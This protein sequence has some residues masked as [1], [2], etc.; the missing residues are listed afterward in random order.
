[1]NPVEKFLVCLYSEPNYLAVNILENLLANNCFVNIVTEDV[2]GWIEKTSY[3]AAKNRFSVGNSKSFSEN[4]YYSYILFCSGFLDKKNL[5]QDVNKFLKTVDYQNKKTFFILPGEV[6]GEI[7]IGLQGDTTNAGII[8]LGDV[9]GP[10]IDLQSN[11]KIP[12]YLN[13]I[14]NSRSLTMPV[15]E[16]LY[17]IF[18][19]DAAKQLVKWLFAFGPFGKEI[20]LIGQDTSSSTFWQVNTKLIGEIKLNTVTDSASGKL[21]KGVE[22]FRINKDLTFTLTETYKWISLKPV[23]QTRKPTKKHSFKKAKILILTLLL[24]F[25]LPI[26]TLLINGGLSYFSYRQFLSG[27]SQVSQNLLYVNKFVSNIGYFES[28]VLKHIP[29]IGHFYKESEYMSYVITN[30]SK[31]GIE[32]IPV[33]RTGG[34]LISNILGD[35]SYSFTARYV[36]SKINFETYKELISQT[37]IIVDK[38]PNVLGRED[39]KTYFVLFENNMELRPTGGF[40]GSYGLLTFD[41]GRLSDFAISD[42]YSADGQLNGHV[43]PPL[44][45]KQY[46][47]EANWWLRDS[48]WD[49]DFPTSA[50][51]A[52]WFLDKEMDKQVDGVISVDLTPIKSFLKIS[53]PIFL[54]DYNM[55]INADNL[56]EK[57]QSEVQDDFFAGTHKKASFLTALSRSIL[58][59]TGGLSSTQKTSVLKLVYDNLDQR[60]IQVFLHDSE[61]QNTMEVLGWDGSVFTP[62]CSGNCYSDLVGIVEANVGVNKSNYFVTREANLDIEIDEA[63]ID[64][65]MTLT[66]KNSASANLGLSGRYKSYVRLLIPE[67]SIAIRAESS[68]GQNT[69]V[70]NPEITNSKGR[71]EV[72]TIVEVLAGETKQLVFYWSAELSKQVDQYDVYIRK[73][74]GVDGYPVNVSVTDLTYQ[75]SN[76][77]CDAPLPEGY[78]YWYNTTLVRDLF[79]RFSY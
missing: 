40:I 57:V 32:G 41:K 49:P 14:I 10:R 53:G 60:H 27:N 48:N 20:F 24:I 17:P 16:I 74:A 45:I 59:K 65:T 64:K 22:I 39:S 11:L 31:M 15:G 77:P 35:S 25:L 70:L 44:P 79:A 43:E 13:E 38:L 67:N 63:R 52:E 3:I 1:M 34:E 73:Q 47:G 7:K 5:G 50:K 37:I 8:Y 26:L 58:D 68:I 62:A 12:N 2:G 6:Y 66:L 78:E 30:A 75:C 9:L 36:L 21:P 72:G 19:S 76:P 69:V 54:S 23:K 71:K 18:V 33:V 28:R 46:L 55:S 4:I 29:L 56:Y 61:F 51:R 42:V